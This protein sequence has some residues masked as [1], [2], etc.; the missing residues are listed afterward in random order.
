MLG[1][2]GEKVMGRNRAVFAASAVALVF[3]VGAAPVS[4]RGTRQI[5][6]AS[7][8]QDPGAD[9]PCPLDANFASYQ[10]L[11][12]SGALDGCW[13]TNV[14]SSKTSPSGAYMES[15]QEK[16]VGSLNGGPEGTFTTT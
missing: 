11:V 9:V 7:Y 3:C 4:A 2:E 12:L 15:G 13:Y 10:P 16:F 5:A 1:S 14:E 6:G 8:Y